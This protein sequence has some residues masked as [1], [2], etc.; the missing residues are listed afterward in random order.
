[1]AIAAAQMGGGADV[2]LQAGIPGVTAWLRNAGVRFQSRSVERIVAWAANA[3]SADPM[4]AVL[5]QVWRTLLNDWQAKMEQIQ[6]L[7][8]EIASWLLQTPYLLLLSH[9]GIN[10]VSAA[11]LA[12]EMG[13]IEHYAH[14]R[15]ITGRAGLFPSRYQSDE[16]DKAGGLSRFRNAR[17]RSAWLRI[18]DNLVKCNV[19]WR[20]KFQFW[21]QKHVDARDIRCRIANRV[22]RTVFQMVWSR[23]LYHH[24]SRLDRSYVMEKILTFHRERKTPPHLIVRDLEQAA[25]Q[26]P[27]TAML[28]EA[29]ALKRFC[30]RRQQ[31]RNKDGASIGTLLVAVLAR[32]GI[33]DVEKLQC[34][35]EARSPSD[36]SEARAR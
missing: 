35:M 17:L 12:G 19:Y 2:I 32:Y 25:K 10:V 28:E 36:E 11:E 31:L 9:P 20:G 29:R 30:T 14:A 24:P 34:E 23:Q 21:K 22:T 26:I 27:K 1:V 7:E 15:A 4:S 13:P 8:R 33:T 6:Q 16:V 3:A 18:A 5:T